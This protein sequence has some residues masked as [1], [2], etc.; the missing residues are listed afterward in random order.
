VALRLIEPYEPLAKHTTEPGDAD[1]TA[2]LA[3][4][5]LD[6]VVVHV[7]ALA[8]AGTKRTN[9]VSARS[10]DRATRTRARTCLP[11]RIMGYMASSREGMSRL[12]PRA[13]NRG[14]TD[15]WL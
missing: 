7:A 13:W 3:A 2:E 12:S 8:P 4:L 11:N 5:R 10:A 1:A 6:T 14:R 9:A 15:R